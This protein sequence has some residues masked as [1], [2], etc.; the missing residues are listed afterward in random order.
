MATAVRKKETP[1]AREGEGIT[2]AAPATTVA[3]QTFKAQSLA[4]LLEMAAKARED[5]GITAPFQIHDLEAIYDIDT[6][7][8]TGRLGKA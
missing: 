2:G 8:W 3:T 1:I 4:E 5:A 7:V 6:R